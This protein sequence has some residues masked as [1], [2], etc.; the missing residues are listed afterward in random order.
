MMAALRS[1]SELAVLLTPRVLE[2][3]SGGCIVGRVIA[4]SGRQF[5]AFDLAGRPLG[6]F[7]DRAEAEGVVRSADSGGAD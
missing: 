4:H 6:T 3:V 5:D 1:L 7:T 2:V